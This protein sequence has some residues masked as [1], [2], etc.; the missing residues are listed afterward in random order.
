MI[1]QDVT[2]TDSSNCFN[3]ED[4]VTNKNLVFIFTIVLC[5]FPFL[6]FVP[7][8]INRNSAYVAWFSNKGLQLFLLHLVINIIDKVSFF[9]VSLLQYFYSLDTMAAI[10]NGICDVIG[11]GLSIVYFLCTVENLY[12]AYK[13]KRVKFPVIGGIMPFKVH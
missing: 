2:D 6:F 13:G 11:I 7:Y 5:F 8:L 10:V 1:Q 3:T 12:H 9:V 4:Y